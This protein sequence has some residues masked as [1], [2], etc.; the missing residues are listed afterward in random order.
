ML[1]LYTVWGSTYLAIAIAVETFPPFIMAAVRFGLA[2][3]IL[4][5]WSMARDRRSFQWPTRREW[6]DSAIVGALLLGGGMGLVAWG[7]QTIPSG[8]AALI[9]ATMPVWIAVLGGIFLGERLPRLAVAG[10]LIGFAGVAILVGPSAL[11][12]AGAMDPAG[13]AAILLSPIAWATGSLF[14]SHRASL[15]RKPLV[16]TGAQMVTGGVVLA[17]MGLLSGEWQTFDPAAISRD[18]FLAFVYLTIAGSLVAYTTYSWLLGVAPLPLV[19]TYA[20][21]NPIVA[22]ILGGLILQEPIDARTVVAGAVI[23]VAV[24]LIVTA[25]GRLQRPSR[26]VEAATPGA[27][28]TTQPGSSASPVV[29]AP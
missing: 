27:A 18:S 2:G 26:Q 3:I 14:A 4:L 19:S 21:V 10:I 13:I 7:E 17:V 25:R 29:R 9:I 5:T 11:G 6:R 16:A 28:V 12:G 23:V 22:V 15:P 1:V 20:Y 24:A 8:I